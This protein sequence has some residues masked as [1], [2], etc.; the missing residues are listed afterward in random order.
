MNDKEA[1]VALIFFGIICLVIALLA[2]SL[3]PFGLSGILIGSGLYQ[4]VR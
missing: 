4:V 1:G 2:H 3:I